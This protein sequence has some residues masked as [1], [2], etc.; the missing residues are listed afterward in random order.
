LEF[1]IV[2]SEISWCCYHCWLSWSL[3]LNFVQQYVS[4]FTTLLFNFTS[5]CLF[6]SLF[7]CLLQILQSIFNTLLPFQSIWNFVQ[8]RK[9]GDYAWINWHYK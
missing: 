9:V 4:L 8:L 7:F 5:C 1:G 3:Q 2:V 6:V